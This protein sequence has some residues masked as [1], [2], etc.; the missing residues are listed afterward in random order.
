VP[1]SV[2]ATRGSKLQPR[3][4][5]GTAHLIHH[6]VWGSTRTP[7]GVVYGPDLDDGYESSLRLNGPPWKPLSFLVFGPSQILRNPWK[8]IIPSGVSEATPLST[9]PWQ[10]HA[11][12]L[13]H[14]ALPQEGPSNASAAPRQRSSSPP[15]APQQYTQTDRTG[16]SNQVPSLS[17]SMPK[18]TESM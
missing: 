7:T 16:R 9:P 5:L 14:S 15:Q 1:R 11:I 3:Q 6:A 18:S 8:S 17:A 13:Q 4:K 10:H 12:A 2:A